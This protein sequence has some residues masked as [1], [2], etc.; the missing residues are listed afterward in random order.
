MAHNHVH[1]IRGGNRLCKM[2]RRVYRAMLPASTPK[3]HHHMGKTPLYELINMREYQRLDLL[4]KYQNAPLLL[5]K[6][7]H[8]GVESV[9]L[10]IWFIPSR[11]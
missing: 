1:I 5:K 9:E 10:L 6:L 3:R 4:Q 2:L 7:Y 8:I 11:I